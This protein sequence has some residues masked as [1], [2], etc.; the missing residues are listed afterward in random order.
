[1]TNILS[2]IKN[3][4]LKDINNPKYFT[5]KDLKHYI[6]LDTTNSK[7]RIKLNLANDKQ[8]NLFF[9]YLLIQCVKD[10]RT[11]DNGNINFNSNSIK[12]IR[13][14]TLVNLLIL[15][16]FKKIIL[17]TDPLERYIVFFKIIVGSCEYNTYKRK[18]QYSKH[19][20]LEKQFSRLNI[21]RIDANID[22]FYMDREKLSIEKLIELS[23]DGLRLGI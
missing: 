5:E 11:G 1:M 18:Y 14:Y 13:F 15:R 9:N 20:Y 16:N 12:K 2:S 17:N 22:Y 3:V 21:K 8:L 7:F 6:V 19:S 23:L 4:R 10:L